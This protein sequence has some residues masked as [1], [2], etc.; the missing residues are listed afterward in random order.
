MGLVIISLL[1]FI[2]I[3][4]FLLSKLDLVRTRTTLA[5]LGVFVTALGLMSGWGWGMIFGMPF[6]PLQQL[7][8]FI[9]LG[10]GVDVVFILVKVGGCR[11]GWHALCYI[12][13]QVVQS[14]LPMCTPPWMNLPHPHGGCHAATPTCHACAAPSPDRAAAPS[15]LLQP[16]PLPQSHEII[17]QRAPG[18]S[19]EDAFGQ[20]M[21]TAGLSVQVT[22]LA[23]SVAF[24]LGAVDDLPSVKWFSAFATLNTLMIMVLMVGD[25]MGAWQGCLGCASA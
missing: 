21:R 4:V 14:N 17:V 11:F 12:V 23:S 13:G 16:P 25:L 9:L 18:V 8:P 7:S 3:A 22:L 15:C 6:T 10:M 5:L 1:V 24:A 20:L 2:V 19:M